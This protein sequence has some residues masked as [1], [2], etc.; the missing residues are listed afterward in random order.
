MDEFT[1]IPVLSETKDKLRSFAR[2][3][4]SY[5]DIIETILE[6]HKTCPTFRE[7]GP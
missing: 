6:H 5:D 3:N 4:L 7:K 2:K 1:T